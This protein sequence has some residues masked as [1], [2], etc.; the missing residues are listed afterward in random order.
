MPSALFRCVIED[1]K[2]HFLQWELKNDYLTRFTVL[3]HYCGGV[4]FILR[5]R[6][7]SRSMKYFD[8]LRNIV[9]KL[10]PIFYSFCQDLLFP[11]GLLCCCRFGLRTE[12][13]RITTLNSAVPMTFSETISRLRDWF[14]KVLTLNDFVCLYLAFA[15]QLSDLFTKSD[16]RRLTKYRFVILRVFCLPV[17]KTLSMSI[18]F[19]IVFC[20]LF[21]E[22][23]MQRLITE[24]YV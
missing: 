6:I 11:V 17:L 14:L 23:I 9:S 15:A 1:K 24:A 21:Y 16:S 5:I 3:L 2:K 8:A 20:F 18:N 10:Q 13:D 4:G 19:P 22:L 12:R 7:L